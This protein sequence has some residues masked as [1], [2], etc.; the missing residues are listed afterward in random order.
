M[1]LPFL[2]HIKIG[3]HCGRIWAIQRLSAALSKHGESGLNP[4][5][6]LVLAGQGWPATW[7]APVSGRPTSLAQRN[8]KA[9]H[10]AFCVTSIAQLNR[11]AVH[12]K[13]A[14]TAFGQ[15]MAGAVEIRRATNRQM[16]PRKGSP[17]ITDTELQA[18]FLQNAVHGD[19]P[20]GIWPICVLHNII[21]NLAQHQFNSVFIHIGQSYWRKR[22]HEL[23]KRGA[24]LQLAADKGEPD[25]N[26]PIRL[27]QLVLWHATYSSDAEC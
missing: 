4:F 9:Q 7:I 23:T 24:H 17:A 10:V 15:L 16:L 3:R 12:Q 1:Q 5:I 26:R 11:K 6:M 14:E 25:A 19:P 8:A 27:R 18:S 13:P 22:A 21:E 2:Y 20:R